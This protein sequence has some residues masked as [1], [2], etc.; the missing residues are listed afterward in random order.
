MKIEEM[1]AIAAERTPM[2]WRAVNYPNM[3]KEE[4]IKGLAGYIESGGDGLALISSSLPPYEGDED[5]PTIAVT[6]NGPTSIANAVFITMAANK[7]DK[8]LAVA[9]AS[10]AMFDDTFIIGA[11]ALKLVTALEDLERE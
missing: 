11:N 8:L 6:G 1:K 3:K 2:K 7:I 5:S 9:E 10:K 4:I